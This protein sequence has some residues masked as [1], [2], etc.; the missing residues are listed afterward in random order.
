MIPVGWEEIEAL[1]LGKL[2]RPEASEGGEATITGVKADS[3]VV[4]PGDLFVA[5]NTGVEHVADAAARGAATLVPEDQEAA[6]AALATL[7]RSRSNARVVAVVGS[8]GKTSTKDILGG[9]CSAQTPTIWAEASQNN[10]IGL[11]L[12]VCRLEAETRV[13]VTEMGMRG[14][15]QIAALCDVARPDVVV[16]SSIGPEHLELVGTVERVA[17]ANAEAIVALPPGGIAVIPLDAPELEPH[18]GRTDIDVRRFDRSQVEGAGNDWSFSVGGR[19]VPLRLPFT[20]RHMAENTLAALVAY[21]ALGLSLDR[22]QEGADA[23]RMSRWRGEE[24]QLEGGG[25]VINDAYNAN[26]TSMRA[27]LLDL[28]ARA[29]SRRRVAILGEMAELGDA[30]QRYHE[31]VGHL[32]DEL[33]IEIVIAVGDLAKAYV[34]DPGR[35]GRL[36]VSDAASLDTALDVLAPGDVILVKASRSVGLEGIPASIQKRSGAWYES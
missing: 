21:D 16:V 1:D 7:V 30:S 29:G 27:A 5:L 24:T 15:G 35:P 2:E 13:L 28:I 9:L 10:G 6:L 18:L 4:G 3:R 12:T 20:A 17:E 11:P 19:D 34:G 23:I 14:L 22:A 25:L 31:D 8:T 33:G 36:R 26:P 32:V